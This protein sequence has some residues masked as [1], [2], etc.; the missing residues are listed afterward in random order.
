[1]YH[2]NPKDHLHHCGEDGLLVC[3]GSAPY[4]R[5]VAVGPAAPSGC[6]GKHPL[7]KRHTHKRRDDAQQDIDEVMVAG[8]DS[9]KP[10]ADADK[11][12]ERDKPT[13]AA[14]QDGIDSGYQRVRFS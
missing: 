7:G 13:A 4:P 1:M 9:R 14:T 5:H 3:S 2:H 6:M 12:E 10:D 11:G 8:V